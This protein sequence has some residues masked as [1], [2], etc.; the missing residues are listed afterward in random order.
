[1]DWKTFIVI[2][3]DLDGHRGLG[4]PHAEGPM[5]LEDARRTAR[6][7]LEDNGECGMDPDQRAAYAADVESWD[8]TEDLFL[9]TDDGPYIMVEGR[10]SC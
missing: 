3:A 2:T 9:E 10:E 1:M 5:G 7:W 8:G 4:R 6:D